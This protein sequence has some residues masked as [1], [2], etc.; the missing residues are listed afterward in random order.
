MKKLPLRN[1]LKKIV[2]Y[3]LVDDDDFARF[4]KYRWSV[5]TDKNGKRKY[6]V[7]Y[8]S[9]K[10]KYLA[11]LILNAK[12]GKLVDHINHDTFDNRKSQIRICTHSQNSQ[13]R[14]IKN[15][16]RGVSKRG[17]KWRS[18]IARKGKNI[19]LGDYDTKKEAILSYDRAVRR[20]FGKYGRTN[21]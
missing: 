20:L 1:R 18:R 19:S 13:N 9:G 17:E 12:K 6:V 15:R 11:R 3:T 4:S 7:A 10:V 21:L 8:V 5:S 16:L 14:K 2:G